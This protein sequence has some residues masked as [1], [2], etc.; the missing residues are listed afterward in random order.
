MRL[1]ITFRSE[2]G[3]PAVLPANYNELIQGLIYHYLDEYLAAQL[4]EEGLTDP[5]TRR[6]FK[7]FTFSRLIPLEKPR[8]EKSQIFFSGPIILIIASPLNEFIQ[9]MATQLIKAENLRLGDETFLVESVSVEAPP[10][11]KEKVLIRVLSPITVYSTLSTFDGKKK[12]YYYSAFEEEFENLILENLNKKYRA[13]TGEKVS[14]SGSF[15][16]FKV[17]SRN[18]RILL[19]KGT[20]IKGWDGLYELSLPPPLFSLAF[21]AGLGSKNSQGFGCIEVWKRSK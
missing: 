7:F 16:P 6:K 1:K 17:T 18:Q 19:Y 14:F 12:T 2:K 3:H 10:P 8:V 20:V 13:L 21:E 5:E 11:Y 4:H 15:R 9:S